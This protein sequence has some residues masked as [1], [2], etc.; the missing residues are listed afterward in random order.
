MT[1]TANNEPKWYTL[2]PEAIGKELWIDTAKGFS[3][4]VEQ[5]S[6]EKY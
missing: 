3:T 4:A 2:T 6:L 1:E 5:N